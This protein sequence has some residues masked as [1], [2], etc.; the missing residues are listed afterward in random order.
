MTDKKQVGGKHYL[1]KVQPWEAMEAWMSREQFEGFM[2]GNVLKYLARYPEKNGI[3]DLRK[4]AHYLEKLIEV[5]N[6][7]RAHR[8]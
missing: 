7:T 6:G 4:A 3:E 1:K 5:V 8:D 2:R